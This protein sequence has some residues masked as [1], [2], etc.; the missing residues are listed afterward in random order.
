MNNTVENVF[1]VF[2]K[3]QWLHLTDEVTMCKIFMS[4][5]S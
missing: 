2:P 4:I 5:F 3:V 1:F